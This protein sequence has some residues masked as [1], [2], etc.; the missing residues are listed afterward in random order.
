MPQWPRP[1]SQAE[2]TTGGCHIGN[3]AS[4]TQ[5]EGQDRGYRETV[6][7]EPKLIRTT[8]FI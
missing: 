3:E 6:G 7:L 5:I 8:H 4:L 1:Q 2:S